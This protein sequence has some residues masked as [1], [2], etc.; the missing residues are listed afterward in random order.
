MKSQIYICI[1]FLWLFTLAGCIKQVYPKIP[2][3]NQGISI[4]G[5]IFHYINNPDTLQYIVIT[6]T[7]PYTQAELLPQDYIANAIVKV[8]NSVDTFAFN[9]VDT[10][11]AYIYKPTHAIPYNTKYTLL[12][13]YDGN[14]YEGSDSMAAPVAIDSF[15]M[16]R[17]TTFFGLPSN[18][19]K[20]VP[21][22]QYTISPERKNFYYWTCR[23]IKFYNGKY[24]SISYNPN[25]NSNS[26]L[27]ADEAFSTATIRDSV[28]ITRSVDPQKI[29]D[30][31]LYFTGSQYH[32]SKSTYG[33]M[34][35]LRNSLESMGPVATPA[36]PNI[37]SNIV[38][39]TDKNKLVFGYFMVA[40]ADIKT[41]KFP[42]P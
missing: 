11:K 4:N 29:K 26:L 24:D 36:P 42:N 7:V 31:I 22:M 19:P 13:D 14:H 30:T 5:G 20:Y 17:T 21:R 32:I 25:K 2:F 8:A 15:Y 16:A 23:Y 18:P 39:I 34:T 10:L 33:Y 27:I 1:L 28:D 41:I 3:S 9:Y 35:L 40:S 37:Q 6:K 38:C 12:I